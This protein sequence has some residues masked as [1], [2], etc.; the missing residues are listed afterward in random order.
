MSLRSL[1][2]ILAL[3]L[4]QVVAFASS[5]Y[6]L[7]VLADPMAAN[8]GVPTSAVFLALSAAFLLSAVLSPAGGRLTEARG[9]RAVLALSHLAFAAALGLMASAAHPA[10]LYLG[11]AALGVGMAIGLYGTAF[12]LLVDVHGDR[13]RRPITAVSLIGAFGG[14]V[15]W[16]VSRWAIDMWDWRAACLVWMAAHLILCLPLILA[17][18]P[19][20]RVTPPPAIARGPAFPVSWDRRMV[21]IAALFAGAWM[22]STAMGAHLPRLL[23]ALGLT[24]AQ[25]AWGAGAMAPPFWPG[26]SI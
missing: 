8:L 13:A 18:A 20:H 6:L 5:Y 11:V 4:G 7:G 23:S 15:G 1:F 14:V 22:V 3:G 12:A 10:V 2:L 17:V 26:S 19:R 9:G 21:Q 25:A 24:P 16:P